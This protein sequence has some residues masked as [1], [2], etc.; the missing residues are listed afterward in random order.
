MSYQVI[1]KNNLGTAKISLIISLEFN[2]TYCAETLFVPL[3][4][5]GKS[6]YGSLTDEHVE[7]VWTRGR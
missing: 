6:T 3:A 5:P 4:T 1:K 2:E 7:V